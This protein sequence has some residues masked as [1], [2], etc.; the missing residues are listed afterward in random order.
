MIYISE[1]ESA[2]IVSH[3]LAYDAVRT[4]LMAACA[5]DAASFPVVIGHASDPCN[6]F[7]IKSAA[8]TEI[9]GLKVGSYFPS[10]DK[11]SRPR[12]NSIIL[13]FDQDK[14][15]I[16]AIVEAGKLNAYRTAA[17]NAVATDALSRPEAEVL[18]LF[19]TGHQAEFEALAVCRIRSIRQV[20]I[21][22]RNP[23][24]TNAFVKRLQAKGLRAEASF[25]EQ[26]CR[27]ADIIVT[28]T[29]SKAPLFRAEWV[30]S[31]SHISSM[32]SD[33]PG[34]QEL[35]PDL[36]ANASLF[37]DLPT[38]SRSIGEFQYTRENQEL[39]AIGTVLMGDTAGRKSTEEITVFDSSGISLQDLYIAEAIIKATDSSR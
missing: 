12:H 13:L 27:A 17:A 1:T 33:A 36:L 22:G 26:A 20:L 15:Q 14:G 5:P 21:V 28:A 9:A 24:R 34:K 4:A 3:K 11:V 7:T 10:N 16:G 38:Q 8:D 35:P 18:S 19:G 39:K 31:G 32:G 37:C 30:K 29:T 23:V 6:R 25:P 2:N